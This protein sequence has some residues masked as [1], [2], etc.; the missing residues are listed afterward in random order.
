MTPSDSEGTVSPKLVAEQTLTDVQFDLLAA[1]GE[2]F[3]ATIAVSEAAPSVIESLRSMGVPMDDLYAE[4]QPKQVSAWRE[5]RRLED[6]VRN[7]KARVEELRARF[8]RLRKS[9]HRG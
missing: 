6:E 2:E 9:L 5:Y 7:A 8:E 3:A 1:E 4:A